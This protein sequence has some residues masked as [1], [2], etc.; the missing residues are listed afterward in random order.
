MS[1]AK[2][3]PIYDRAMKS[4]LEHTIFIFHS[5]VCVRSVSGLRYILCMPRLR[6]QV[7]NGL[8]YFVL[9]IRSSNKVEGN[10]YMRYK[11]VPDYALMYVCARR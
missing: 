7:S 11:L 10:M 4:C 6:S 2:E 9:L 5:H 1:G 8:Q 3:I